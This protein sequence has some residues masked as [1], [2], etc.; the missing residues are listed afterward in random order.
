MIVKSVRGLDVPAIGLGT[1]G[2][3]GNEGE[4]AIRA[5]LDMG[6]RHLDTAIRYG[7]EREVGVAVRASGINRSELF[8]TTK[9]WP[10]DHAPD[11]VRRRVDESLERLGLDHVDLLLVHWPSKE[12]P[13]G[14][15]LAA[16]AE[17]RDA[18]RARAIGVSNFTTA[19]LGEAIDRHG[20][21]LAVNQVEYHPFLAQPKLLAA[22]R[23]ADMLMT[24][25]LPLARG[26]VFS[27]EVL[28]RIGRRHGKSAG[29]VALRW[30]V[31]QDNVLAIPR[32]S[33][34]DNMRANIDIF[35]FELDAKEMAEIHALDRQERQVEMEWSPQWDRA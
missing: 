18:G 13:L 7:N 26:A 24:A 30:L 35:D 25:Y 8:V 34:P 17:A 28:A 2:L 29:Q 20:A 27:D 6:Y 3:S 33:K 12:V 9:I 23:A 21:E 19:L 16:F 32:S 14:E 5:A 22:L 1:F 11:M 4:A 15:T 31:Q 10:T